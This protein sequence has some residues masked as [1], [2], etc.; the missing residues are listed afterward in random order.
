VHVRTPAA[1]CYH[2]SDPSDPQRQPPT[3]GSSTLDEPTTPPSSDEPEPPP[4]PKEPLP[5]EPPPPP[6]APPPPKPPKPP[7]PPG[8]RAQIGATREAAY[9][10]VM[11]HVELAKAEA[12]AIG[13]QIAQVAAL[14]AAALALVIAAVS[15]V[16]LGSALFLGEWV[17]GSMGWGVLH[18]FLAFIAVAMVCI[19]IAVG[20]SAGRIVRALA[21]GAAI[22]ILVGAILFL[23]LPNWA[24]K[25]IGDSLLPGVDPGVRPLVVGIIVVGLIGLVVGIVAAWR[26]KSSYPATAFG[27]LLVGV[28]LG[29]FTAITFGPQP[30]AGVGIAVGY[31]GWMAFMGMD[32]AR[33]G[34]DVEA[35]KARFTPTQTIETSKETLEWLQKRMPP[36]IG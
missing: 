27:G 19:F 17:L 6:K 8:F 1:R 20:V 35:L 11:A 25:T 9:R 5:P 14:G 12:T 15:I 24:Y 10:L 34:I 23:N 26:A 4:P 18:G 29:A 30:A 31:I 16:I 3:P 22:G 13:G 28:A 36:G 21:L 7:P 2:R 33:T 32:L